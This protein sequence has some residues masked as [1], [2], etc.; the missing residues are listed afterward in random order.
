[1]IRGLPRPGVL[2]AAVLLGLPGCVQPHLA[3]PQLSQ[4]ASTQVSKEDL[5]NALDQYDEFFEATIK[6][7]TTQID[8]GMP[9]PNTRKAALLWKVRMIP[10]NDA[11]L[12][13]ADAI[14]AF[15]ECWTLAV[16]MTQY[17]EKG[18][19]RGLF[20][21]RQRIATEAARKIE[22]DIEHVGTT[23]LPADRLDKA[24][25][26][27]QTFAAAHPMRDM[28]SETVVRAPV[29]K[30]NEPNPFASILNVPLA[31]FRVAEGIDQGA[32]AIRG[33]SNVADRFTDIVQEL[34]ESIRWQLQ[35]LLLDL[36]QNDVVLSLLASMAEFSSSTSRLANTAEKMP[37]ELRQQASKLLADID[38][39]Q[40]GIQ[41]TLDRADKTAATVERALSR[42]DVVAA[43]I[44]RTGL[45]VA[46]AGR[47]WEAT[48]RQIGQ[49]V[50]DIRNEG[51]AGTSAPATT[52]T[53][54]AAPAT[55]A[56]AGA[57]DINDYRTTADAMTVTATEL[58]ALAVEVRGI[59][60]SQRLSDQ[61]HDVDGRVLGAVGQTAKQARDLSDHIAWRAVQLIVL[62]FVLLIAY[63]F[64]ASRLPAKTR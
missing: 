63:R 2:L 18:D 45:S 27:V 13:E 35:L 57:F 32:G 42:V 30:D 9:D 22:A 60:D 28:F 11:A 26:D 33:F 47:A 29:A 3:K 10:A 4:A 20:G 12:K 15:L 7:A 50:D 53:A 17:F 36:G 54:G 8:E 51:D 34:P 52:P 21:E 55:T 43:S 56:P 14:K 24:R 64:L 19:G 44:D 38:A 25:E 31:P 61:I 48:A 59:L 16:R 40:A 1:M 41:A 39:K 5:R 62:V 58:R 49:T 6:Q 23:F 37:E 46:E